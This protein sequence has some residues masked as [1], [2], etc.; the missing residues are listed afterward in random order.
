[1]WREDGHRWNSHPS[2]HH[3]SAPGV[4][5]NFN[6]KGAIARNERWHAM[7]GNRTTTTVGEEFRESEVWKR[8]TKNGNLEEDVQEESGNGGF[9]CIFR[10]FMQGYELTVKKLSS[11]YLYW[12]KSADES[13]NPC[14]NIYTKGI[15]NPHSSERAWYVLNSGQ[16]VIRIC[17]WRGGL[18]LARVVDKCT[19]IIFQYTPQHPPINPINSIESTLFIRNNSPWIP[20]KTKASSP[21][22]Q[23]GRKRSQRSTQFKLRSP[24]H[25]V[26]CLSQCGLYFLEPVPQRHVSQLVI[27]SVYIQCGRTFAVIQKDRIGL[28]S[29]PLESVLPNL[30]HLSHLQSHTVKSSAT[31]GC[32]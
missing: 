29:Y 18:L 12:S 27:V 5:A 7:R 1:M 24:R 8:E 19:D 13:N 10:V 28:S 16:R 25:F 6:H 11:R 2:L 23:L 31:E 26:S 4:S 17:S 21:Y 9:Y 22:N 3:P 15:N 32:G 30:A 20:S 14:G